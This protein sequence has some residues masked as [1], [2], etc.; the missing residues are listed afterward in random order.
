MLNPR[1]SV[2]SQAG[3]DGFRICRITKQLVPEGRRIAL[4]TEADPHQLQDPSSPSSRTLFH[5]WEV[6]FDLQLPGWLPPTTESG[7]EGG[8]TSYTLYATAGFAEPE[9]YSSWSLSSLYNLVRTKQTPI[10]A[11]QVSIEL[12]RHRS[13]P[14]RP[15]LDGSSERD[16][17][18]FLPIDHPATTT[19][20][21]LNP[22]IPA[23]LLRSLDVIL[24]APQHIGC[25]ESR[26]PISMRMRTTVPE[27][28]GL[29]T[30]RLDDFEIEM[31]QTEKFRC[32]LRLW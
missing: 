4:T 15:S 12:T 1:T 26:V 10:D 30:L 6:L 17:P 31:N 5:Q 9:K 27:L 16:G 18:L 2:S 32:V 20:R 25:E 19:I 29:G 24:T 11:N 8:G 23:E 21:Q 3:Y 28:S 22:D 7:E 14:I 13:P